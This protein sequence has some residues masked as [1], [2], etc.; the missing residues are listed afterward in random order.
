M[1][2]PCVLVALEN[3]LERHPESQS[4]WLT[5]FGA[6]FAAHCGELTR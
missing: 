1:S 6:G 3:S 4:L 5:A 2:S